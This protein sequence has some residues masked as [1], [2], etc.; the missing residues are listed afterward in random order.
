VLARNPRAVEEKTL[1]R[2]DFGTIAAD[3]DGRDRMSAEGLR[4]LVLEDEP[5]DAEL[6]LLSLAEGGFRCLPTL[7]AGRTAFESA[8]APGRF[9]LVLADYS[10]PDYTG[11]EALAFVR[12]TDALVPFVL[13]SGALGEERAVEALRAGATDYILKHGLA[14]LA[15]AVRRA[16][17]ERR[18]HERHLATSRALELSQE[19]LRALSGR[20]L[21][22]QEEERRRLARDLHDDLGQALTALKIQLES[23]AGA[24]SGKV[25]SQVEECVA[26][27]T[28]AL[29]RVRQLSLSLRPLQLDD[30]GLVAA[31]RS[32]LDRQASIGNL[33]PHFDAGEAPRRVAPDLETACFRVAQEAITNVLRHAKAKHLWVRLFTADGR[34]ALSVRDDGAGF[35]LDAARRRAV[36]GGNLGVVGMEER[37]ALAGGAFEMRTAPGQGTALL[38]TFPLSSKE[39][40]PAD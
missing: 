28:H 12:R 24:G 35:D 40:T 1:E 18:E 17:A 15:P 11:L 22:V 34:L 9:E 20:L 32:H 10:L 37:V 21:E 4:V 36:V 8:F 30:L 38:A 16:L 26:T 2:Q 5:T 39:S 14:R 23:L 3:E 13:V 6:A 31:L 19:R 29:E 7:A 27:T 33:T 25:R